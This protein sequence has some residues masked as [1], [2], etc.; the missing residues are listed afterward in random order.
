MFMP[1]GRLALL[2]AFHGSESKGAIRRLYLL[3][4][5]FWGVLKA[6]KFVGLA[7]S[8]KTGPVAGAGRLHLQ[9]ACGGPLHCARAAGGTML[10]AL[11]QGQGGQ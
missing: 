3:G 8:G 7:C 11:F 2:V 5:P 4:L 10:H 6:H 1:T 9:Q